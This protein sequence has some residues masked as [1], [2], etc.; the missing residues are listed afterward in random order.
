MLAIKNNIQ[1]F[2]RPDLEFNAKVL[3]RELRPEGKRKILA[4][5]FYRL[6]DIDLD[7]LKEFKKSLI[8]AS[9]LNFEKMLI[10]GDFNL[11]NVNWSTCTANS[12]DSLHNYFA[13]LVKDNFL[14]QM[15]GFP[16]RKD[17]ILA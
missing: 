14:W 2:R 5:A 16:M 8:Y 6:P 11:P 10:C 17:N 15:I 9:K 4:I 7:Y 1:G 12:S 13:K 3:A